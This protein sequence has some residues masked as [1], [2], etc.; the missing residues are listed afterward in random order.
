MRRYT[1]TPPCRDVAKLVPELTPFA[2]T[3]IR[4][5]LRPTVEKKGMGES[6]IGGIFLWQ[7]GQEDWPDRY[8][9]PYAPI[10]QLRKCDVPDVEFPEDTDLFQLL[11][12]PLGDEQRDQ[13]LCHVAWRK[14]AEVTDPMGMDPPLEAFG[15]DTKDPVVKAL[16][17]R[18]CSVYPE[19]VLEYPNIAELHELVGKQRMKIIEKRIWE[20]D[21]GPRDDLGDRFSGAKIHGMQL[22]LLYYG[23]LSSCPGTKVGGKPPLKQKGKH[24]DHF[25]TLATS[26]FGPFDAVT[27]RRWVALEDQRRLAR[28]GRPLVISDLTRRAEF[29]SLCKPMGMQFSRRYLHL[30]VCRK[31]MNWPIEVRVSD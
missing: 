6:K 19:R 5:H 10:V 27:F 14:A 30:Y 21:F 2:R 3:T 22:A 29:T 4:L 24:Y 11:W 12:Y 1:T 31:G 25:L 9:T 18:R 28:S 15:L 23:E 17:P 26:E 13:P 8:G 7:R 20:M 16:L